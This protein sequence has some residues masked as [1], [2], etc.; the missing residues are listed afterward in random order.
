MGK[1]VHTRST[2]LSSHSPSP[3]SQP[4]QPTQPP[5]PQKVEPHVPIDQRVDVW[6]MGCLLF[7][8]AYGRSPFES[9][10]EGVLK[11]GILRCGFGCVFL[12]CGIVD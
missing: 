6:A 10:T 4:P 2:N 8:A 5:T 7:A 3:P 12:G 9:P 1:H 11:L